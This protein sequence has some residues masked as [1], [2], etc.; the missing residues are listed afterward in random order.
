MIK[1][2][3]S[4]NYDCIKAIMS[5]YRIEKFDLDCTYSKGAFWKN[6]HQPKIKSDLKPISE[7]VI[8][9]NSNNLPFG[10][11]SFKSIMYDPPFVIVGAGRTHE[12]GDGSKI[13]KRFDGFR[14]FEELKKSYNETLKETYRVLEEGGVLVFKCQDTVSGG[15]NHFTHCM[16]MQMALDYGFYPKDLFV[17]VANNRMNAFNGEK[18]KKQHHARKYHSFFWV[19]EKTKNKVNYGF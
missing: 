8:Q 3:Y 1:S 12:K 2:V 7:D 5:L 14:N 13:A 4:S 9:A 18:W 19:F 16:V 10:D 17:L 15:K 11:N 6:L